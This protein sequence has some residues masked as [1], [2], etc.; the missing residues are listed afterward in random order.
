MI[1]PIFYLAIAFF[2]ALLFAQ[3][4][5]HKLISNRVFRASLRGHAIIPTALELP[6]TVCLAACEIILALAWILLPQSGCR[7]ET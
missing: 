4:G 6:L 5:T 7:S 2:M 3:A 1:A